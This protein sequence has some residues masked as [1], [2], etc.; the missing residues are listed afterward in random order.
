M[1]SGC[2]HLRVPLLYTLTIVYNTMH[3][4]SHSVVENIRDTY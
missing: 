4:H 1:I 3:R 2:P